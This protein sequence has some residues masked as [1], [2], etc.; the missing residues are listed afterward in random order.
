M[1]NR[2]E[3]L[4][5]KK[6]EIV[7]LLLTII[8]EMAETIQQQA[9]ELAELKAQLN[10]NSKNS[11]KPPS[12]D[13]YKKPKN[14]RKPS[15]KKPGGQIGHEGS[16]LKIINEPD[17]YIIHKP[18]R[19]TNCAITGECHAQ[20]CVNETR[21]EI[22][23]D[24][25]IIKTAHQAMQVQ[26]PQTGEIL[27]GPFPEGI[28]STMQYGVN[29]EALAVSLNTMGMMSVNR[30]HEILNDVFGVPIST[31]TV[32]AMVS[33][34]AKTISEPVNG[35]KEA[36]KQEPLICVD[37]TGI[38]AEERTVWAHTASTE[39]LTYIE[40]VD[41]RG[42]KGMDA[43]GILPQYTGTAI[44]D[45]WASY[46]R[47]TGIRHGLCN[48][49]LLRELTAVFENTKQAWAQALAGLFMEMKAVKEKY[50]SQGRVSATHYY[51]KKYQLAYDSILT[52]ALESNPIPERDAKRKGRP[53][54]GKTGSLVDRLIAHKDKYI[55]FFTDFI[56]PFD[57][58][59]AE[60][61]IRML[62]VK[63][64]VSGCFRTMQGAKNYAV[65]MSYIGAA[66]KHGIHAFKAI[67]DALLGNC[68]SV[69]TSLSTE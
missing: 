65:I 11:S 31:G 1:I 2:E 34:F 42:S 69:A 57:N 4:Q 58:N 64:K 49:H 36:V 7:D 45:C 29:M 44:H 23:I 55:L 25:N 60:R 43:I 51:L 20:G 38:R 37:E 63:L 61:D 14:L 18:E 67:K 66:R 28:D 48:A 33:A 68:F 13:G 30:T 9:D 17:E 10:K 53:K 24:V 12:S 3:L 54:R 6:E 52:S 15:G 40:V 50:V 5:F 41:K 62:K 8:K 16:G 22:D 39:K 56:V 32:S 59:Q 21:Y 19:C 35:I 26:C 46:F 27:T 47:Y